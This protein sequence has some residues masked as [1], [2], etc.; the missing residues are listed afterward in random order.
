MIF[1]KPSVAAVS[2]EILTDRPQPL[3]RQRIRRSKK[4]AD[5]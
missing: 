4:I 2:A 5:G 1:T 3:P